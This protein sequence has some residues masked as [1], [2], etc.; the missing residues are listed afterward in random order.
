M[1][2]RRI[3]RALD[4]K[5]LGPSS[6]LPMDKREGGIFSPFMPAV[7][8]ETSPMPDPN[9]VFLPKRVAVLLDG[10]FLLRALYKELGRRHASAQEV[11]DFARACL[12]EREELFRIYFNDCSPYSG[13]ADHP[14]TR[15][16]VEFSKEPTYRRR[17]ELHER[18]AR[19]DY[20]ALRRGEL[21]FRGWNLK[22][23]ALDEIVTTGRAVLQQDY[24]PNFEQKRVDMKIGLDVAWLASRRIVDRTILVAADSDFTPAVK[25]ARREGIQVVLDTMGY[26]LKGDV[27]GHADEVRKVTF[28]PPVTL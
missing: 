21:A 23:K 15:Q 2:F 20:V 12:P 16:R 9:T 7:P 13:S 25:F 5:L 11:W 4:R 1:L 18:L 19:M 22:E 8:R 17:E 26:P 28:P 3:Q 24:V 27:R 6:A 10:G 14:V